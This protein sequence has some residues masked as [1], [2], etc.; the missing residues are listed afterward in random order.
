MDLFISLYIFVSAWKLFEM[1]PPETRPIENGK[2]ILGRNIRESNEQHEDVY[3][4]PKCGSRM[5]K[6]SPEGVSITLV[7]LG[8]S[9]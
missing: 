3:L 1:C 6:E 2:S 5:P 9:T 8:S 4:C 7:V